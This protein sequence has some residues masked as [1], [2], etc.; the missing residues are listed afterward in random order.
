MWP[1]TSLRV[2][3][4]VIIAT[5][6]TMPARVPQAQILRMEMR[7]ALALQILALQALVRR[8]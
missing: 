8:V 5:R 3:V 4:L 6:I 1:L 2:A 7:P